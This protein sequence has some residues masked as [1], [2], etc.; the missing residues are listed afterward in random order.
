MSATATIPADDAQALR[1]ACDALA[2]AAPRWIVRA[3]AW[4][5]YQGLDA[6]SAVVAAHYGHTPVHSDA[7]ARRWVQAIQRAGADIPKAAR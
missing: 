4:A 6:L 7:Q 5:V 1:D 3:Y 2:S